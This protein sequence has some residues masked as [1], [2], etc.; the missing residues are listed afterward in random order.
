MSDYRKYYSWKWEIGQMLKA[1]PKVVLGASVF[2][3]LMRRQEDTYYVVLPLTLGD[4]MLALSYLSEFKRQK[5][6]SHVTA[7]CTSN[8]VHRLCKYYPDTVDA[9]AC[10]KEWELRMLRGFVDSLPGEYFSALYQDRV[11]FVFLTCNV[12]MRTL[13]DN[14]TIDFPMYAK[15]ILYKIGMSS[16]PELPQIPATDISDF[17]QR[18]NLIK[19]KTVF[20]NS[21]ANS[22]HCDVGELLAAVATELTQKGYRVVTL[23]ANEREQPVQGTLAIPCTLE[24]A[25]ALVGYGGM[26]IGIRSGFLDLMVYSDCKIISVVDEG[27]G[28]KD[29]CRIERLGVNPDCHT[30][31]YDGDSE[32]S[33]KEIVSLAET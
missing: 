29:M 28:L 16:Q 3:D 9:V 13:W 10:R 14:P 22:V 8:Y 15:A 26:L 23:T 33:L 1:I 7:V 32:T 20:L 19:E 5:G 17:V 4:T 27:Y 11:T 12:S 2:A 18:Y 31:V 30:V 24:E 21:A 25:F 6:I